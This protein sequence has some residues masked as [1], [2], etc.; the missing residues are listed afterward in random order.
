[1]AWYTPVS[2]VHL[3]MH[4]DDSG[5]FSCP[6]DSVASLDSEPCSNKKLS[7]GYNCRNCATSTPHTLLFSTPEVY[8]HGARRALT[9]KRKASSGR[10]NLLRRPAYVS[11]SVRLNKS[12]TGSDLQNK[13]ELSLDDDFVGLSL[14]DNS[15]DLQENGKLDDSAIWCDEADMNENESGK[16]KAKNDVDNMEQKLDKNEQVNCFHQVYM[17][18]AHETGMLDGKIGSQETVNLYHS[19]HRDL[20]VQEC[21]LITNKLTKLTRKSLSQN[22]LK[23]CQSSEDF[24]QSSMPFS[25][26]YSSQQLPHSNG[27]EK[28]DFLSLLGQKN[29]YSIIVKGILGYLEPVDLTAVALVSKT[30]NRICTSDSDASRRIHCYVQ[31]KR[32]NKENSDP[33]QVCR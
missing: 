18:T 23:R 16:T 26:K 28:V 33:L 4:S 15:F 5:Y 24:T 11:S 6:P 30:W 27:Q 20:P 31:H 25:L 7:H 21:N 13:G 8:C 19:H 1:M 17:P 14:L 9:H 22:P 2:E 29:D 12:C 32:R 3:P 10:F